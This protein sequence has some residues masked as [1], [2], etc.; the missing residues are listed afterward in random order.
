MVVVEG[1]EVSAQSVEVADVDKVVDVA[2]ELFSPELL[3]V[4]CNALAVSVEAVFVMFSVK[5]VASE[6]LLYVDSVDVDGLSVVVSLVAVVISV[7]AVLVVLS[8][9]EV[10]V[11]VDGLSLVVS[12]VVSVVAVLVVVSVKEVEV[13]VDGLSLAVSVVFVSV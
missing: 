4:V 7:D 1:S 5:A 13:E 10:E 12:D 11:E 3:V 9:K 6:V 2:V 8:V